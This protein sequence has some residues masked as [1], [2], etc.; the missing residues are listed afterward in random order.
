MVD[1]QALDKSIKKT[2]L[3]SNVMII[4]EIFLIPSMEIRGSATHSTLLDPR[5]PT[6]NESFLLHQQTNIINNLVRKQVGD[7]AQCLSMEPSRP[8]PLQV[9]FL[10]V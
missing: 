9:V 2:L 5:T 10:P 4:L 7:L 1:V 8:H 3:R 6:I